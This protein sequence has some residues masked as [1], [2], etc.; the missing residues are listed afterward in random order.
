[1]P[2]GV[3]PCP[4]C[5]SRALRLHVRQVASQNVEVLGDTEGAYGYPVAHEDVHETEIVQI[6]CRACRYAWPC[7]G[8][9]E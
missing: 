2:V 7:Q 1:M 4:A 9:E 6:V 8:E 5:G 3:Q